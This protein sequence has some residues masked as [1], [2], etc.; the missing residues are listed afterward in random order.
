MCSAAALN[1]NIAIMSY[2]QLKLSKYLSAV[3]LEST[4]YQLAVFITQGQ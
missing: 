4:A 2:S 1:P 3:G